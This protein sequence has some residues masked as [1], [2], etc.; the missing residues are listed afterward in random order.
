MSWQG[1][2]PQA[3]LARI[4]QE[5]REKENE[6]VSEDEAEA[7]RLQDL[8]KVGTVAITRV[9]QARRALLLSKTRFLQVT[10]QLG[11]AQRD[12]DDFSRELGKLQQSR[13]VNLVC[14]LEQAEAAQLSKQSQLNA[15]KQ[16]LIHVSTF[17]SQFLTGKLGKIEISLFREEEGQVK[18]IEADEDTK[19]EPADAVQ[20][21]IGIPP[22]FSQSK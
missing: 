17:Q 12:F 14:D 13:R 22:G 16:K 6:G 18:Q 10:A 2:L 9:T 15:A 21:A 1:P 4:L 8:L 3:H 20:I 7:R 19:L 11:S 5:Q